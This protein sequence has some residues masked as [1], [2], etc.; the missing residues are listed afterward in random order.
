MT[1]ASSLTI[2]RVE[3]PSDELIETS[4]AL[5][6]SLMKDDDG[7]RSLVGGD[8]SSIPAMARAML[9]AGVLTGEYYTAMDGDE[10]VGFTMWM[11]PG[12]DLFSTPEERALGLDEF[13]KNLSPEGKEYYKNI[14]TVEWPK[15]VNSCLGGPRGKTDSWWMHIAMV[16]PDR[17]K[18]GIASSL[19]KLVIEK[20]K[21]K[22]EVIACSTTTP[23]N[24]IIYQAIGLK[25][26]GDRMMPSPWG[27]WPLY[28][29]S[30]DTSSASPAA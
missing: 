26:L 22:G 13:M 15:F 16:R 18:Q 27:D 10:L 17:Q 14:Y 20:A 23:I 24:S 2:G 4:V 1:A 6:Y 11:P 30:L 3:N 21:Q 9:K 7:V 8:I 28:V 29:L 12:R 19:M 25:L 5:F